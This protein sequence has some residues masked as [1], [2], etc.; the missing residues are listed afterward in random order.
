MLS[1]TVVIAAIDRTTLISVSESG[2]VT[3]PGG[4]RVATSYSAGSS[5]TLA[6]TTDDNRSAISSTVDDDYMVIYLQE[7]SGGWTSHSAQSPLPVGCLGETETGYLSQESLVVQAGAGAHLGH[8]EGAQYRW[9]P[10]RRLSSDDC[11][12]ERRI[13]SG[14]DHCDQLRTSTRFAKLEPNSE[15][16]DNAVLLVDHGRDHPV[17]W[18]NASPHHRRG[19]DCCHVRGCKRRTVRDW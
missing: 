15:R 16:I 9:M 12:A 11:R 10:S 5:I 18:D 19:R 13:R 4:D 8:S 7:Q 2:V 17:R 14:V 3:V 6:S 1:N